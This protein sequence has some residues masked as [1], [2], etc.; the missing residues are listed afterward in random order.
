MVHLQKA[1]RLSDGHA[2]D[3][4]AAG[5]AEPHAL[6]EGEKRPKQCHFLAGRFHLPEFPM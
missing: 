4:A 5:G 1:A 3:A 2:N 6:D